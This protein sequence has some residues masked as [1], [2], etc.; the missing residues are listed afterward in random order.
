MAFRKE[1]Y[2]VQNLINI[3]RANPNMFDSDQLDVLQGK[4]NQYGIN[5][6]PLKDTTSLS[7]LAKCN[8]AKLLAVP[9]LL[10]IVIEALTLECIAVLLSVVV[11]SLRA[12]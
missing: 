7:S 10:L 3:Y 9:S 8:P 12:L 11:T 4:A 2:E 5:F 1:A 6:K